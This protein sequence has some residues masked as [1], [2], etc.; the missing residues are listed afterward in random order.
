MAGRV[1]IQFDE[2]GLTAIMRLPRVRAALKQRADAIAAEAKSIARSEIDTDFANQI[3][4]SE[5]IRP[6]GRPTAKVEATRADAERY[7]YGDTNTA[8]R[9]VLGRAAGVTPQSIFRERRGER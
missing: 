5:E 3:R 6:G 9:R 2:R 8:R 1:R 7:E 4:V